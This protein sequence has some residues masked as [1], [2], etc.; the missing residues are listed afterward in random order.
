M[1]NKR[2]KNKVINKFND[3]YIE[4]KQKN[5]TLQINVVGNLTN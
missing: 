2:E 1:K 3:I 4:Y 5:Y